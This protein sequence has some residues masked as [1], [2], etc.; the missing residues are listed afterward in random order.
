MDNNALFKIGYGLYVLTAREG[1]KDNGCIVN[2]VMQVT[3]NPATMVLGVCKQNYT[4]GMITRTGEFNVSMLTQDAPFKVFE[5]FG[6]KSGK[7]T[8]KFENCEQSLR[9][10]NG[11]LYLPK[12]TNAMLSG[13]VTQQID[14]G[15]H[16]L[17]VADI[18]QA[19]T[20]SDAESVTYS[21]YQANIKPKPQPTSVKGWRC[22]ICGYIYEGEELPADYICPLCKHGAAD[23][24]KI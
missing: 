17:F 24:E 22:K 14:M 21:Y 2:T 15:S 20:L 19:Q 9:S 13:K 18:T 12:Y 8:N 16:T 23:F 10:E 11:I 1:E 4:H 5:H 3:P 6:F 7:D